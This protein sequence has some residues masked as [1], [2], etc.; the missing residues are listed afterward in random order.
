MEVRDMPKGRDL[1]EHQKEGAR[2]LG[3]EIKDLK[4]YVQSQVALVA[5]SGM[6]GL[7]QYAERTQQ[8]Q[9]AQQTYQKD[10]RSRGR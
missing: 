7:R 8:F 1:M 5:P 6:Q 2:Q 9:S 3:L 10:D 4:A